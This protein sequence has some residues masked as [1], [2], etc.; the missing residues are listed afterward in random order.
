MSVQPDLCSNSYIMSPQPLRIFI[1]NCSEP[2]YGEV[3]IIKKFNGML[4]FF[5]FDCFSPTVTLSFILIS[6]LLQQQKDFL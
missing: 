1:A 3:E 6:A 4:L 2:E 5:D